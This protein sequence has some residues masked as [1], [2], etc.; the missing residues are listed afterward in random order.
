METAVANSRQ[1]AGFVAANAYST[2]KRSLAECVSDAKDSAGLPSI[3]FLDIEKS[4]REEAEYQ[5]KH[6]AAAMVS[7]SFQ[8]SCPPPP[9]SHPSTANAAP[10]G[11][12]PGLTSPQGSRRTSGDEPQPVSTTRQSLPSIHEALGG[13]D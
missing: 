13:S 6:T 11:Q 9:Y 4:K 12:Q 5:R 1:R 7:P 8:Y 10:A 3:A 2:C